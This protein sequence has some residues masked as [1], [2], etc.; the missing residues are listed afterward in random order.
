M[1]TLIAVMHGQ[2][3]SA[4]RRSRLAPSPQS[5]VIRGESLSIATPVEVCLSR[6]IDGTFSNFSIYTYTHTHTH[7]HTYTTQQVA[8]ML[9]VDFVGN[10]IKSR[11][12]NMHIIF[13]FPKHVLAYVIRQ[14]PFFKSRYD[15]SVLEGNLLAS[16]QYFE[17]D[18]PLVKKKKSILLF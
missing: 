15:L 9:F 8:G 6:D 10:S 7:T 2:S 1:G 18:A 16:L 13:F 4:G 12:F 3:W 11:N 17:G 5:A 14:D